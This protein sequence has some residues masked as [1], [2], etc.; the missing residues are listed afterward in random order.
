[1]IV[2]AGPGSVNPETWYEG[3]NGL[4]GVPK[5]NDHF[6]ASVASDGPNLVIGIPGKNADGVS[7]SGAV[8][9]L[10]NCCGGAMYSGT[11][12]QLFTQGSPGVPGTSAVDD[13]FGTTVSMAWHRVWIGIPHKTVS[14]QAAAG[15]LIFLKDQDSNGQWL[16]TNIKSYTEDGTG[17][18]DWAEAGDEFAA[19]QSPW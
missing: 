10:H 18:P 7:N 9:I 3:Y 12:D 1:V 6:G 4:A 11:D 2:S 5:A 17:V 14:G 16:S 8:E 13:G 15:A 19:A